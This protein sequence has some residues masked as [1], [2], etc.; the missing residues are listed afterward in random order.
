MT[1]VMIDL[2]TWGKTPGSAIRSIGAVAFDPL[3]GHMGAEFYCNISTAS[4]ED[5]GLTRDPDTVKWWSEQSEEAQAA[6]LPD[7]LSLP[8]A[9]IDFF[10]YW[11]SVGGTEFWAYGPNFDEVVLLAAYRAAG[12]TE[13][14]T[15]RMPRCARTVLAL[16]N[17]AANRDVGVHHNALWD[18]KNQA[19]AVHEA[20][21]KL[22]LAGDRGAI[23]L[24]AVVEDVRVFHKTFG[25]SAP[26]VPTIQ[27]L[28]RAAKRGEWINDEVDELRDARTLVDQADAYVDILY[29]AAGGL[30]DLGIDGGPLW[31]IVH[32]ANMAK[33]QPDGSVNRREDGKIIKPDGW[34][35]P[36][37]LLAAE[38]QRQLQA[39]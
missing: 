25:H 21:V 33:L 19:V 27:P 16:A 36:E 10:R 30:V 29:F 13:P 24:T 26:E 38:V 14:W 8:A 37:P 39:A 9:L 34:V 15:Y 28:D 17:V 35:A 1:D 32:A 12:R 6:L 3:T 20:Y 5:Y 23:G 18:A 4:C 22:G 7:R 31:S 2:E 11:E